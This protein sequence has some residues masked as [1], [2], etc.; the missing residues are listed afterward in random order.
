MT[1]RKSKVENSRYSDILIIGGGPGGIQAT[2]MIKSHSPETEVT[3]LRPELN[4]LIYCAIPYAI[5]NIFPLEK[6]FKNDTY[7]KK[8]G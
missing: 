2:R 6:V 3:V 5:E 7:L 1:E 8:A 4:S